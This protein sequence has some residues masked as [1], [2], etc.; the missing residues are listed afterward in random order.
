MLPI[1]NTTLQDPVGATGGFTEW[2]G[3]GPFA[4]GWFTVANNPAEVQ[5]G[6]RQEG[7]FPQ[8]G[9]SLYLTP[10]TYPVARGSVQPIAGIRARNFIAGSA[11]QFFGGLYSPGEAQIVAGS[12]FDS[13]VSPSGVVTPTG[14]PQVGDYKL[15]AQAASHA[16]P[17]GGTWYLCDGS[18]VPATE[19]ALIALIGGSFPDAR[20]RVLTALGTNAAVNGIGDNDGVALANRRPQHQ[21]TPHSHTIQ[22][23][24]GPVASATIPQTTNATPSNTQATSSVDG[25]SGVATDATDAPAY[26]V[27]G[28]LFVYGSGS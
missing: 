17:S 7:S 11:A 12:P 10:A 23:Y 18:V 14:V 24:A 9:A 6:V 25:G 5:L 4:G 3:E 26:I 28:S 1:P 16:E 27:P 8:W 20:G 21:H 15:S 19:A 22:M 13:S 2:G